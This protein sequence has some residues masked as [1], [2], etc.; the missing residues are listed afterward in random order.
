MTDGDQVG[1]EA[2]VDDVDRRIL[3]LLVRDARLSA[4][5][6]AREIGMSAGAVSERIQ[7][8]EASG[9]IRGYRA[10]VDPAAVGWSMRVVVGLQIE[11]GRSLDETV[12]ALLAVPEVVEV[13]VV[14]GRWDLVVGA[15]VRDHRHLRELVTGAFW[16]L[17]EFRHSETMLVLDRR[18]GD[19]PWMAD[20]TE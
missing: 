16:E 18:E 8:L 14:S 6:I 15:Q 7:R 13:N 5:A 19:D 20:V 2:R 9:A 10:V 3:A 11:Q 1:S 12:A 4:R 17:P